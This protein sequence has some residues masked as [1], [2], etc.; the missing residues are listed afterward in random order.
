VINLN[1]QGLVNKRAGISILAFLWTSAELLQLLLLIAACV[2]T[3]DSGVA[4]GYS[5][6]SVATKKRIRTLV[7]IL[8]LI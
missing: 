3:V 4:A 5:W 2:G 6:E 8:L 1:I 7:L